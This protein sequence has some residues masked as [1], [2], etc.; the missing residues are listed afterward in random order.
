MK[1]F[2]RPRNLIP[3]LSLLAGLLGAGPAAAQVTLG[4][5]DGIPS[6]RV[7]GAGN[8][9]FDVTIVNNTMAPVNG[10]QRK[11]ASLS[12]SMPSLVR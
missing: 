10:F 7:E 5:S 3:A 8:I 1:R 4:V 2:L 9:I 11:K 12:L 6:P